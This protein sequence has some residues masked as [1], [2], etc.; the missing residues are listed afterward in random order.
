VA[1]GGV[2]GV[3][4]NPHQN[5]Q[6][7]EADF[8]VAVEK[9]AAWQPDLSLL[10]QGPTDEKRAHRGDPDVAISLVTDYKSLTVFGHTRWHWPWLMTLGAS[11]VMNVGGDLL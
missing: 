5:Q 3:V 6:R 9:V 1:V 7:T 10:H 8:L 4:G 2:S 11:Q